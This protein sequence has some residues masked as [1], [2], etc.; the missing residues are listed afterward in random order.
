[1]T[2]AGPTRW[3]DERMD[4]LAGEVR[5]LRVEMRYEFRALRGETREGFNELRAEIRDLR[6][7][8][9]DLRSDSTEETRELRGEL[10]S[11]RRWTVNLWATTVIGFV[12]VLIQTSLR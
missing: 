5:E 2:E 6:S 9:K 12:A 3:T 4:D 10:Y 1:M 8:M 11:T 7:D